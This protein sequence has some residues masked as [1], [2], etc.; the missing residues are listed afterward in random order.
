MTINSRDNTTVDRMTH[1]VLAVCRIVALL[2]E[3]CEEEE[4][5]EVP[6]LRRSQCARCPPRWVVNFDLE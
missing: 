4:E 3:D 1:Y 5:N 2:G 6:K